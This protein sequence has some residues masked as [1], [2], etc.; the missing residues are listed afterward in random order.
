MPEEIHAMIEVL[1]WDMQT[2]EARKHFKTAK[3]R[4]LPSIAIDGN[5]VYES[6]IPDQDELIEK[7]LQCFGRKQRGCDEK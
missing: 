7:I 2:T 1:E 6:L 4:K 3:V 5:V